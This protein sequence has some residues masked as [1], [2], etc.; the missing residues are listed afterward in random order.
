MPLSAG[1]RLCQQKFIQLRMAM[2]KRSRQLLLLA[3][4]T[5]CSCWY[6]VAQQ[7]PKNDVGLFA[8]Y[9]VV[10]VFH[11]KSAKPILS[12]PGARLFR[13][14][15]RR[16]ARRGVVFADHYAVADWGCGTGCTS[17]A[18]IDAVTGRVYLFPTTVSQVNEAG[19]ILSYKRNSRAVHIIGY[20]NEEHSA[21]RWYV[22][23]GA[24]LNLVSEKPARL[25]D[26]SDPSPNQ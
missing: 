13:T 5:A 20:L 12:A 25:R 14:Q 19:E 24:K 7:S 8:K 17:F 1:S 22:W 3:L 23:D 9:P 21:D 11:G 15:I 6:L 18:I 16:G 26:D 4:A 2:K 10:P